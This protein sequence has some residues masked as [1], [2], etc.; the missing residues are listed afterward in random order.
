MSGEQ[1]FCFFCGNLVKEQIDGD[2]K[3][4]PICGMKFKVT[5]HKKEIS[6]TF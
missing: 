3:K 1:R 4:C 2:I 6:S 5:D